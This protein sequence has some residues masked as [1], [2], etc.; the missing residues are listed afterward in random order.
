MPGNR[1]RVYWDANVFLAYVN[2]TPD[3]M[4][5]LDALMRQSFAG[6]IIIYTSAFSHVEVAFAHS[7]QQARAP[8]PEI[9]NQI[10]GLWTDRNV[11]RSIEF[12]PDIALSARE[13][14]R[15][16]LVSGW[17]L[18]PPDAIHLATA[19]WLIVAGYAIEEFHTYDASLF[20]YADVVG[21]DIVEPYV[22]QPRLE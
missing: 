10:N 1:K 17:S 12:L 8:N 16:G 22:E 5:V 6:E 2:A 19:Q 4:P 20:R 3:H 14:I 9:E 21:C 15:G 18:K 11:I 13:L 7:E